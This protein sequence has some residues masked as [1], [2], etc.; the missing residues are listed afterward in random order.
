MQR[1]IAFMNGMESEGWPS[2]ID[3]QWILA[4]WSGGV[5]RIR[6]WHDMGRRGNAN[7]TEP[8]AV[9]EGLSSN[10]RASVS[11][12][13][14]RLSHIITKYPDASAGNPPHSTVR[15]MYAASQLLHSSSGRPPL[16][17][18]MGSE[19]LAKPDY[20][21]SV[22]G[23]PDEMSRGRDNAS[24][25]LGAP[26]T[27]TVRVADAAV[28]LLGGSGVALS[29]AFARAWTPGAGRQPLDIRVGQDPWPTGDGFA[30]G[31]D[32]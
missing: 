2:D 4:D 21:I 29:S 16:V 12:Q 27:G 10:A 7:R 20:P 28:D 18:L 14:M 15:A 30:G 32:N 31:A 19:W 9:R 13:D 3:K 1:S 17:S 6:W 5:N 11:G 22:P 24:N 23:I 25:W 26:I 8:R